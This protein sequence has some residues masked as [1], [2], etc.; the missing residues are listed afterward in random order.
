MMGGT[1]QQKLD[2][3]FTFLDVMLL[4]F[5]VSYRKISLITNNN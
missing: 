4:R 2:T 1:V 3:T 5:N